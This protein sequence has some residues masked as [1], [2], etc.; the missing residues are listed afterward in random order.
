M[1]LQNGLFHK[2][3]GLP[4]ASNRIIFHANLN[5]SNHALRAANNDRYGKINLPRILNTKL[6]NVTLIELETRNGKPYKGVYRLPH[7][8]KYDIVIVV[9]YETR[10]VKTV[11]L[12]SNT[13]KH[14]TLNKSKYTKLQ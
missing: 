8:E 14:G 4:I 2:D 13:D 1:A 11:W 3:I 7:C 6:D 9:L 10:L 5:Y 12:N